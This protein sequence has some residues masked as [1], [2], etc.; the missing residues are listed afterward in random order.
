MKIFTK[1]IVSHIVHCTD[2]ENGSDRIVTGWHQERGFG[3]NGY[4]YMI[5]NGFYAFGKYM[6]C[7]DG[8]IVPCRPIYYEGA[9]CKD[10]G[11]NSKSIGTCL[12]GKSKFSDAQFRSLA[13]LH[14][15][16][17][18]KFGTL[19]KLEPHNKYNKNKTCPNFNIDFELARIMHL[20]AIKEEAKD[21]TPN[22]KDLTL[23]E[24]FDAIRGAK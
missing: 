22:I 12:V 5:L 1:D 8:M 19:L 9:H 10:G 18:T 16:L 11:M 20:D 13:L 14:D 2:S 17:C 23:G 3:D 7:L 6:K 4:H 21:P 24:I 15:D